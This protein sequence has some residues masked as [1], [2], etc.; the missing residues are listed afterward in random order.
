M[1]G[2]IF[3]LPVALGGPRVHLDLTRSWSSH[4][5]IVLQDARNVILCDSRAKKETET[6]GI[7]DS[8]CGS[9]ALMRGHCMGRVSYE[10]NAADSVCR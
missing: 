4:A 3:G 2:R 9:L 8:L 10:D 7:F 6:F 5:V 1:F